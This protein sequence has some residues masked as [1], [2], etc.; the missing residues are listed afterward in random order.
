[1]TVLVYAEFGL[2]VLAAC[3]LMELRLAD[4]GRLAVGG[5]TEGKGTQCMLRDLM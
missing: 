1:M 4:R 2:V 3:C 5:R